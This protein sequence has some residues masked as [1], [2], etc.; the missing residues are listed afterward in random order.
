[1]LRMARSFTAMM[2]LNPPRGINAEV[3]VL[4]PPLQVLRKLRPQRGAEK[5]LIWPKVIIRLAGKAHIT[6][7]TVEIV[8]RHELK[9][10]PEGVD[11]SLRRFAF[12]GGRNAFRVVHLI[13]P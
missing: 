10:V 9:S 12:G 11:C 4:G 1:M 6:V 5:C 2:T 7:V 3:G 13:E 8:D